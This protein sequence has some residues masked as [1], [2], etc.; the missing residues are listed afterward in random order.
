MENKVRIV[1]YCSWK[2]IGSILQSYAI[3]HTLKKLGYENTLWLEEWN[4]SMFRETPR[5]FKT[6]LKKVAQTPLNKKIKASHKKRLNFIS[7][8]MNAEYFSHYDEFLQKAHQNQGDIYLAGSDQIWSPNVCDPIY[9]LEFAKKEH[10]ISY[11]A[12]MGKTELNHNSTAFFEDKLSHF[13][14]ISVR[15]KECAD[16][17]S[18]LTDKDISVNIDPTFLLD[19]DD[20]RKIEKE[21]KLGQSTDYILVYMLYWE[22]SCNEK[23]NM[24]KKNTGLPVYAIC[25]S[26]SRINADKYLYDV[27]I[28]EFLWLIDHAKYVV[29]S[30]FHGVA[31]SIL[32]RKKFAAVINPNSPSRIENLLNVLAVPRVSI[33]ELDRTDNFAYDAVSANIK[34]EQKRSIEYLREAIG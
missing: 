22:H 32:F 29:T 14:F 5:T 17:L 11:A 9:F 21:Y 1:T 25:S 31:F 10:C 15:E 33:D 7:K 28:E 16:A 30:S 18:P 23:I 19:T 8:H 4:R 6:L 13:D 26:L 3:S 24:L 27:G 12:S 20:W 2:S 34:K